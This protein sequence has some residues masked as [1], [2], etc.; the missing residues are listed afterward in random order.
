MLRLSDHLVRC[1]GYKVEVVGIKAFHTINDYVKP[2]TRIVQ[3]FGH[4][5]TRA[6]IM[7]EEPDFRRL[8]RGEEIEMDSDLQDGYV[9]LFLRENPVSLGL[10]IRGRLRSQIPKK[11]ARFFQ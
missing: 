2:T 8:V 11:E 5:S 4:L 6:R 9:I 1:A 7:L 3:L 10:V